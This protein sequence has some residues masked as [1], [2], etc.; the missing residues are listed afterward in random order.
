MNQ[1]NKELQAIGGH[2]V[3]LYKIIAFNFQVPHSYTKFRA[4]KAAKTRVNATTFIE[5]GTYLGV[6]TKRCAP[7]FEKVYT[8]ELDTTLAEQAT[9][10]LCNNKNVKVFQGDVLT[11][12]PEILSQ[13]VDNVLVFLDAHFSG[14]VTACGNLPEPAIE[15]LMILSKFRDKISGIIIDD[16]RLF[17]TEQGFPS[18]SSVF[19]AIEELFPGFSLKVALDQILILKENTK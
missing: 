14:G 6:T 2:L 12:L 8:I 11:Q 19:H 9:K 10:F 1:Q 16:F 17:G 3:D 13:D 15:E 4:I 5:T 18:K 7:H